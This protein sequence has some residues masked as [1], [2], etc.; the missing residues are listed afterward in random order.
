VTAAL[1]ETLFDL[2][3]EQPPQLRVCELRDDEKAATSCVHCHGLTTVA[4]LVNRGHDGPGSPTCVRIQSL[5][6]QAGEWP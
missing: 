2:A 6:V 5:I 4:G 1:E 3:G